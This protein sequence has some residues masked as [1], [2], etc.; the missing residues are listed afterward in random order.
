MPDLILYFE[1]D[2][3]CILVLLILLFNSCHSHSQDSSQRS[4]QKLMVSSAIFYALDLLWYQANQGESRMMNLIVNTCYF[5]VNGVVFYDWFCFSETVQ[6]SRIIAERKLRILSALPVLLTIVIALT[7]GWTGWLFRIEADN[8]YVRGPLYALHVVMGYG[9]IIFASV[10]AL[11]KALHK[12]NYSQKQKY[13]ALASFCVI[14]LLSGVVQILLPDLPIVCMGTTLGIL[15]VYVDMQEQF[16]SIDPLTQISN[17]HSLLRHLSGKINGRI[18]GKTLYLM[19]MDLDYFKKINDQHGH[20]EGDRAL[21]LV[22]EVLQKICVKQGC[23]VARYGGDEFVIV[24]EL[25]SEEDAKQLAAEING[26]LETATAA[27]QLPYM[28]HLS[29]GYAPYREEMQ[30]IP[31][32]IA[33]ADE[34]L[35]DVKRARA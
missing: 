22:A 9:Y 13:L 15:Y 4:L 18:A 28:L 20:V 32:F 11:I 6:K 16:I 35:Y 24:A 23:F 29:I 3:F 25:H 14:P 30:S 5:A 1:T 2:L 27:N 8:T 17:R 26:T 12:N 7:S 19:I 31:E 34:R 10:K 21:V 33:A